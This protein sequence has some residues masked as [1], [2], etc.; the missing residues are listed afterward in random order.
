VSAAARALLGAILVVLPAFAAAQQ[1]LEFRKDFAFSASE[2]DSAAARSFGAR[3]RSPA[4]STP[5]PR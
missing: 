3:S 1:V 4:G 2:V 5:T